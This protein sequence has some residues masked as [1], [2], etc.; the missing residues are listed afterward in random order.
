MRAISIENNELIKAVF[1]ILLAFL[2]MFLIL[3]VFFYYSRKKIIQQELAKKDLEINYQKSLL[4]TVIFTQEEERKRIAQ[5]LHDDI[6]SKLN[7][8]SLNSYLLK[9]PNLSDVE[10]TQI[11]DNIIEFTQNALE[12]SR[13]IA[14][15]LLPPVLEK[16]GLHSGIEELVAEYNTTKVVHVIY[17]NTSN[18][19]EFSFD[20]Q[21]HIFRILQELL[22]NAVRHGLAKNVIIEIKDENCTKNLTFTDD[23][24]GFDVNDERVRKGIG[25]KN[26][27]SRVDYLNASINISSIINSGTTIIIKF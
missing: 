21:L 24:V 20:N 2:S 13:R 12:N 11:T 15:D 25:I 18:F 6:S 14:H 3:I 1:F 7:V 4:H 22:N 17:E 8:V 5:D 23:G 16:F 19:D 27:E 10:L 26:I 9:T